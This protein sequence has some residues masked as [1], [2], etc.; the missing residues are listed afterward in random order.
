MIL[1]LISA[2]KIGGGEWWPT[3]ICNG[4]N[5]CH[6]DCGFTDSHDDSDD[7]DDDDDEHEECDGEKHCISYCEN[8]IYMLLSIL[9]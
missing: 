5:H 9:L 2:H 1:K 6:V 3:N 7:K 8:I 4:D